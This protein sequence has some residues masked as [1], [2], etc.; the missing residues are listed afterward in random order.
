MINHKRLQG[1]RTKGL[2][3]YLKS[4][5]YYVLHDSLYKREELFDF[6][7]KEN[8][9]SISECYDQRVYQHM[10]KT[11]MDPDNHLELFA[12]TLHDYQM[13]KAAL[14]FLSHYDKR[15]VVG[16]MGGHAVKRD[17]NCYRMSAIIAKE[18]TEH[19]Y[20]MISGGGPGAMEATHF[21][22]W[23]AG[24]GMEEMD[25]ALNMMVSAPG[26][27]SE[28]WFSTVI[29]VI[30]RYPQVSDYK[31]LAIPTW[32]Y[33]HE[34]PTLF[35]THIAKFFDNSIREDML[36]TEAYGGLVYMPGSAG[37]LQEIFQEAVQDHYISNGFSS[38]IILVGKHYWTEE[39]P[40]YPFFQH[41]IRK[42]YYK[43]IILHLVDSAEEV[44]QCLFEFGMQ[45]EI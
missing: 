10:V 16:L 39:V 44:L 19:G 28:G 2:S 37:T 21:G 24:R 3:E 45:S 6:F 12:R 20:L 31:S 41:M 33:G 17:E 43:N 26:Y 35:A 36:V 13:R 27:K 11:G 40:V 7:I 9:E 29:D 38:P 5:P 14:S 8:P 4:V 1:L 30:D 23:M 15:Q 42:E 25:D 32:F 18:L 34:P 22:A